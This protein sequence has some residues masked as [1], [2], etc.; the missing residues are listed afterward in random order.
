[1]VR[2][3][4]HVLRRD[5]EL[6]AFP[7]LSGAWAIGTVVG[8]YAL[9]AG[10]ANLAGEDEVARLGGV[11]FVALLTYLL[12]YVGI[13]FFNAALI[14]AALIRMRGGDPT[15]WDG[16]A[17]ARN[18]LPEIIGW[19][20]LSSTVGLIARA[21]A[22]EGW[23]GQI[24][25]GIIDVAWAI[26]SYFAIPI[27]VDEG[28]DAFDA[29]RGSAALVGRVWGEHITAEASFFF[30]G[31]LLAAPGF[32]LGWFGRQEWAGSEMVE[33]LPWLLGLGSR[34]IAGLYVL[35]VIVFMSTLSGIFQAALYLYAST[36]KAPDGYDQSLLQTAI[37][38]R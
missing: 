7:V 34:S 2:E 13:I 17:C 15:V 35:G 25:A 30:A 24:I 18:R 10:V 37:K 36:G 8:G 9:A 20:L 23:I 26:G 3:S 31:V 28:L 1:L 33:R 38:A 16:V 12:F 27:I 14:A 19:A 22:E 11:F 5:K 4:W 6:L 29:A 32:L 21:I